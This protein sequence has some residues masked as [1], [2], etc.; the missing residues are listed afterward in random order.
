MKK[1]YICETCGNLVEIIEPSGIPVVCCGKPMKEL[2]PGT[3]EASHEKHIPVVTLQA[4]AVK[5]DV[6]AVQHPMQEE[7]YIPWIALETDRGIQRRHLAPG[8][9]PSVTFAL[10]AGESPKAVYAWCN[11]HGLWKSEI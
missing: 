3:V 5:V 2:V 1:F 9:A 11:L 10:A 8:E 7:H 6:G 4:G